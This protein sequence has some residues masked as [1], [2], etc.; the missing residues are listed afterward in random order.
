MSKSFTNTGVELL[1]PVLN[2]P[3]LSVHEIDANKGLK[4]SDFN[5]MVNVSPF[6]KLSSEIQDSNPFFGIS[7]ENTKKKSIKSSKLS[8]NFELIKRTQNEVVVYG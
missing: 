2:C 5:L 4:P 1:V 3:G 6:D 7:T 8:N